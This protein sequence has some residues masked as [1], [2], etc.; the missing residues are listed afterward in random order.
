MCNGKCLKMALFLPNPSAA[1][2]TG[3]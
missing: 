1:A 2:E 3:Q